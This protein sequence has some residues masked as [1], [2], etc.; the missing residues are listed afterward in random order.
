MSLSG[1]LYL[2]SFHADTLTPAGD[3]I[4]LDKENS[5]V[6]PPFCPECDP[7]HNSLSL[8][9]DQT[10][11]ALTEKLISVTF[12]GKSDNTYNLVIRIPGCSP[13]SIFKPYNFDAIGYLYI[14]CASTSDNKGYFIG[15]VSVSESFV[16][17]T[18]NFTEPGT[19][20]TYT[21][22]DTGSRD[23]FFF[24]A[25]GGTLYAESLG[26]GSTYHYGP[27]ESCASVV[28][29]TSLGETNG[30]VL[31]ECSN[32]SSS[33]ESPPMVVNSIY[34]L[35][36][37]SGYFA[38]VL[39]NLDYELCPLRLSQNGSLVAVFAQN[40]TVLIRLKATKVVRVRVVKTDGVVR[41]GQLSEFD[42]KVAAVYSTARAL[43]GLDVGVALSRGTSPLPTKLDGSREFCAQTGCS[44]LHAFGRGEVVAASGHK[45]AVFSLNSRGLVDTVTAKHRPSRVFFLGVASPTDSPPS[46]TSTAPTPVVTTA[47]HPDT[48]PSHLP[49]VKPPNDKKR[50][51]F[52]GG[53]GGGGGLILF[54]LGTVLVI[55][56]VKRGRLG[57]FQYHHV[58]Q[59]VGQ[60]RRRNVVPGVIQPQMSPYPQGHNVN[61]VTRD[62]LFAEP[63]TVPIV[64]SDG[65][66][67]P[68]NAAVPCLY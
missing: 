19:L 49:D 3:P 38:A 37:E 48:S 25:S 33:W 11:I 14:I 22:T 56:G 27:P 54:M 35:N 16:R 51:I 44:L 64:V 23:T 6:L 28:R 18:R 17:R 67:G 58:H 24:H 59:P 29:M 31:M 5:T 12:S 21:D 55:Y 50:R 15:S 60:D 30:G 43:Y 57:R 34:T 52:G 40:G 61:D 39:T 36:V 46:S 65:N 32:R 13:L 66:E 26:D 45:L 10:V 20:H 2:E 1:N 4:L 41:D 63:T 47:S 42:N 9:S 68:N 7:S 62:A 53:F 8:N